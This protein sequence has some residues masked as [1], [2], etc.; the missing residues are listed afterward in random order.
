[1]EINP[2]LVVHLC[3]EKVKKLHL[4]NV[5]ILRIRY[6]EVP[7]MNIFSQY[8]YEYQQLRRLKCHLRSIW[9]VMYIIG[10]IKTF[11]SKQIIKLGYFTIMS[12]P[13]KVIFGLIFGFSVKILFCICSFWSVKFIKLGSNNVA[14]QKSAS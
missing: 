8:K 6:T 10:A 4:G 14:Y 12:Q 1:M 13:I 2:Y 11:G 3:K 7:S 5:C 9:K